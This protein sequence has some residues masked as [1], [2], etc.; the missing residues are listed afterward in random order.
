MFV[1]LQKDARQCCDA[2]NDNFILTVQFVDQHNEGNRFVTSQHCLASFWA[3]TNIKIS[4]DLTPWLQT[5]PIIS[6]SLVPCD[7]CTSGFDQFSCSLCWQWSCGGRTAA[8]QL[9]TFY[10]LHLQIYPRA[11]RRAMR[12]Q[13]GWGAEGGVLWGRGCF[14][15]ADCM[16]H[17]LN[18]NFILRKL[19]WI[20]YIGWGGGTR[21]QIYEFSF[22]KFRNF[23]TRNF[24]FLIYIIKSYNLWLKCQYIIFFFQWRI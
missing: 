12:H 8:S 13:K 1:C 19:N 11:T 16:L 5:N 17:W 3:Q 21:D 6:L 20:Y 23:G 7:K 10:S 14:D 22:Y 4:R 2:T 15:F 24:K 18:L 9:M